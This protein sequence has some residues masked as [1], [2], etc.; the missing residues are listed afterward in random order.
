ML[1]YGAIKTN[2]G[3]QETPLLSKHMPQMVEFFL[4]C[5]GNKNYDTS[6]RIMSLNSLTWTVK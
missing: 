1:E 5:G 6:L 3:L 2:N 4:R